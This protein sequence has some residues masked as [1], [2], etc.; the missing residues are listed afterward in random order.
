MTE[1][2]P[3][4]LS[5]FL[6]CCED[7]LSCCI[8]L[9]IV[10][11]PVSLPCNHFYCS[12]CLN[13][14]EDN[15]CPKCR[16]PYTRRN[17][18]YDPTIAELSRLFTKLQDLVDVDTDVESAPP[19]ILS[20]NS[21][22]MQ[23]R[24]IIQQQLALENKTL[25]SSADNLSTKKNISPLTNSE[26]HSEESEEESESESES[27]EEEEEDKYADDLKMKEQRHVSSKLRSKRKQIKK[28]PIDTLSNSST[29]IINKT[30]PL[31]E[32]SSKKQKK[33]FNRN[34]IARNSNQ[35]Q[36]SVCCEYDSNLLRC[37]KCSLMV[38]DICYLGA[39]FK[40]NEE[41]TPMN[42]IRKQQKKKTISL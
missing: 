38:H 21:R 12:D 24:K 3:K 17:K 36:C 13:N 33:I 27:E 23:Q 37:E 25:T 39:E 28:T 14:C 22:L 41:Y 11:N 7:E 29:S 15:K 4:C 32:L 42:L 2:I 18:I 20:Q 16:A 1:K 8:C 40:N 9:S 26:Q 5:K 34:K 30:K 19:I 6:E 10:K 35:Y 31:N